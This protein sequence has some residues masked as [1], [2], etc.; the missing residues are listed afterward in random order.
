MEETIGRGLFARPPAIHWWAVVLRGIVAVIFGLF[1]L[2]WP[3]I[4]LV[5]LLL[6]FAIYA[7][8]DG[9]LS[10]VAAV[11][12]R[13]TPNRL[14]ALLLVGI[15]GIVAGIVAF[16]Y[17]IATVQVLLFIVGAWAIVIGALQVWT[18][19][20]AP[21]EVGVRWLWGVAGALSVLFGI[22]LFSHPVA[23]ALAVA[24]MIGFY[25]LFFGFTLI[26]LGLQMRS[27]GRG[28]RAA[29]QH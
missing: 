20:A 27:L 14:W 25:A 13:E 3:G 22:L 19:I 9:L 24:W 15:A 23:G 6:F 2:A 7:V 16:S 26:G 11:G 4:T 8:V 29:L 17:P 1:V 28:L 10:L 12:A 5:L 21:S 18:A